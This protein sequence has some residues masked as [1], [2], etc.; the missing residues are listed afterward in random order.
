[1]Y[2]GK[3]KYVRIR[4]I[5]NVIGECLGLKRTTDVR[6]IYFAD[7]VF[8]MSKKWLYEFLPVYKQEVGLPFIC[9]VRAD[10]VASDRDYAFRLAEGG[11]KSVFFGVESGNEALRNK[12]LVKQLSDAQIEEAAKNLHDAG[13]PFRTYNIVGLPGETLDDAFSTVELNIRIKA[14]YPWCSVFSPFPGTALTSLAIREGYLD[15]DFDPDNLMRSF[16]TDSPLKIEA[17]EQL[18]N[19]Q[20]FFQTA[21]LIPAAFPVIKRL[22]RLPCNIFF[23]LWF[24]LVYFFVYLRSERRGFWKTLKFGLKNYRHVL[25]RE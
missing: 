14:D 3:G 9:L 18:Q 11:C 22:I 13:I 24:G 2:S 20:K 12:V 17:I 15:R 1:M 10:I 6:T 16:F 8:G 7:D 19:L 4:T 5:D 23:T 21:V 25:A